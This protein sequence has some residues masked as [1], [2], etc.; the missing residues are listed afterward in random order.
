M[1]ERFSAYHRL[2]KRRGLYSFAGRNLFRLLIIVS[3]LALIVIIVQSN[4]NDFNSVLETYLKR[5]DPPFVL[6]LF[7]I[8]ESILG[9]IPPDFFIVWSKTTAHPILMLSLL[10][11]LSYLGG[12]TAYFMGKKIATFPRFH[13]WMMKKLSSHLATL[14][15]YGG[16][17]ILFAALFPLPF[18]SITLLTGMI[19]YPLKRLALLGLARF[20]RFYIYAIV[21]FKVF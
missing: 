19:D 4:I 13:R 6:S 20:L 17:L 7:F 14:H 18:S 16:F 11:I 2:F 9:I 15:K 3:I 5:W 8:S 21:L 1:K 12:I 10:A